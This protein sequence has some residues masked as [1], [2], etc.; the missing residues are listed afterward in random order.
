MCQSWTGRSSGGLPVRSIEGAVFGGVLVDAHGHMEGC[1]N[2]RHRAGDIQVH[3]IAGSAHHRK[4]VGFGEMNSQRHSPPGWGQTRGEL[5]HREELAVRRAGRIVEFLQKTDLSRLVAERQNQHQ[6]HGL[7]CGEAP[8]GLRL[9]IESRFAHMM[10]QRG[11]WLR[12][13]DTFTTDTSA[14]TV[15][16]IA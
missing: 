5:F 3:A 4:A 12:L 10:R 6:A 11:Q 9:P 8:D 16:K 1:L 14:R 13:A 15:S 2:G 7:L